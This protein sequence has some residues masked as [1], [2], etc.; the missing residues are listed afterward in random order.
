MDIMPCLRE[1][2]PQQNK[3]GYYS[4]KLSSLLPEMQAGKI[5]RSEKFTNNSHHR[6]RHIRC[7][8]D[9]RVVRE[10]MGL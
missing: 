7:R 4:D 10:M 5:D 2:N 3:G 6:A 1:Q 9:E 8:A